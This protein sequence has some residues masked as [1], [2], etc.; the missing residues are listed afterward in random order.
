[1]ATNEDIAAACHMRGAF[2]LDALA[3]QGLCATACRTNHE[4]LAHPQGALLATRPVIEVQKIGDAPPMPFPPGDRP[5]SGVR[6]LD[7]TRVL[8]GPTCARTL[9]E[10]GADV[11]HIASPHLPTIEMFE[12]DTGH[13]KRQAHLD[14]TDTSAA[15]T[16]RDLIRGAD[17]FSQGYQH[18]S[19]E[20]RGF[21]ARELADLRPGIVYVSINAFGHEGPW[22]ERPGWEQLAQAA[23][24]VTVVQG[25]PYPSITPAAMN[26]YTT[27]YLAALGAMTALRRRATEGGSWLVTASLS[28]T[29]MWFYQ[30]GA[31]LDRGAAAGLGDVASLMEAVD[32]PYGHMQRLRPALQMSETR[33]RW[34]TPSV[35][36]GS[37]DPVWV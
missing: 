21:G 18:G 15:A 23:T 9:A 27:G 26:D 22:A 30:L 5:L 4:W 7:L 8:A 19:L 3:A 24:G 37:G 29:S 20:R 17:V 14:L 6:V 10:H 25:D 36:L 16:L 1:V 28:R 33:P 11:L 2:E 13:G 31:D 12:M 35:P 32:T 34:A